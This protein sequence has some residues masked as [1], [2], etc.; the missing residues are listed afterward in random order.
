M[1]L[2]HFG[3]LV[4]SRREAVPMLQKELSEGICTRSMIS[5]I[6]NED[7][8]PH[9]T[10]VEKLLDRL[11]MPIIDWLERMSRKDPDQKALGLILEYLQERYEKERDY[12]TIRKWTEQLKGIRFEV[13]PVYRAALHALQAFVEDVRQ[14]F[15]EAESEYKQWIDLA[16]ELQDIPMLAAGLN[17]LSFMYVNIDPGHASEWIEEAYALVQR[18][19]VPQELAISVQLTM[20]AYRYGIGEYH[21]A[22]SLLQAVKSRKRLSPISRFRSHNLL[23]KS[24]QAVGKYADAEE[25][26][27]Q[28]AA[29]FAY[30]P[31]FELI[32][33]NNI[34]DL[35][36]DMGEYKL[37]F[38][39]QRR[40]LEIGE[41]TKQ[42]YF[43][44]IARLRLAKLHNRC[45]EYEE[46]ETICRQII[47]HS[48][49]DRNIHMAKLILSETR[50][51]LGDESSTGML[52]EVV[53][54]FQK[55][56]GT[57][58]VEYLKEAYKLLA[59]VNMAPEDTEK[60]FRTQVRIY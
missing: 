13:K 49:N 19:S 14:N 17:R 2:D 10:I 59:K 44:E 24:Y 6:E 4:R 43:V 29:Y 47:E 26:Y 20:S 16:R 27:K 22:I 53:R 51:A 25:E 11:G 48:W 32:F 41:A 18:H 1:N 36:A 33:N 30:H 50:F 54:F 52:L 46:A 31:S 8:F 5:R 42:P 40:S 9:I 21:T 56:P 55:Q 38:E 57:D 28:T 60:L 39:H 35:Y 34:G 23:G 58:S 12:E 7:Y 3:Q 45:R 15:K 37:A